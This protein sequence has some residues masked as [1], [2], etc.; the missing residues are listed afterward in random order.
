MGTHSIQTGSRGTNGVYHGREKKI[1]E[2]FALRYRKA[3]KG[4]ML[5]ILDEYLPLSGNKSRKYAIF[6]LNRFGKTPLR[7]LD[8]QAVNVRTVEKSR[9]KR[10]Y[11]P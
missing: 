7:L 2:K 4:E 8:G 10:V 11:Q 3:G 9:K 1:A 5:R 6:T